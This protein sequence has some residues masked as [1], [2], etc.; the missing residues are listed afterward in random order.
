MIRRRRRAIFFSTLSAYIAF[1]TP[2]D[3]ATILRRCY[4]DADDDAYA[5]RQLTMPP[6]DTPMMPITPDA[7]ADAAARFYAISCHCQR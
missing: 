7:A 4:A 6:A 3:T 1:I 2:P 5:G